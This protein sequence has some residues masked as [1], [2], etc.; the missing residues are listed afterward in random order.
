MTS[1][2]IVVG[3]RVLEGT[4][5]VLRDPAAEWRRGKDT[6]PR[7]WPITALVG[8]WTGGH[9]RTG[10]GAGRA[11]WKAMDSRK[12]ADGSDMS[13]S[14]HFVVSWDGLIWQTLDLAE[15]AIHVGDRNIN[16]RSIGV[17]CCWA[18][19][20]KQA[21]RLGAVDVFVERRI[22]NCSSISCIRP[23][24]EIIDAWRWLCEVL[25]SP[26]AKSLGIDIPRTC[27]PMGRQ[28]SRPEMR[29]FRGVCEHFHVTG[30]TK[31]D[32][33]GYLVEALGWPSR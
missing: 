19:T 25:T 16:A 21:A 10:P 18:G 14:V 26:S 31:V 27:A 23:S 24:D 4:E 8:H 28:F 11:V 30:T 29:A 9:H 7:Q 6:R 33:A 3:G 22:V 2:G 5:R 32:A 15:A 12:N 20:A 1:R 13:V 17:E